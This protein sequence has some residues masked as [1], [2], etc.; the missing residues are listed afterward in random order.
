[1]DRLQG[2]HC[3]DDSWDGFVHPGQI[4]FRHP[5]EETCSGDMVSA[6]LIGSE[7]QVISFFSPSGAYGYSAPTSTIRIDSVA[8]SMKSMRFRYLDL[9]GNIGTSRCRLKCS[10]CMARICPSLPSQ[11]FQSV[12]KSSSGNNG[13]RRRVRFPPSRWT[14]PARAWPVRQLLPT[15]SRFVACHLREA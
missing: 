14:C 1:M 4:V 8:S 9:N 10:S 3:G 6:M 12:G 11:V 15:P 13:T 5:G 2:G 7:P